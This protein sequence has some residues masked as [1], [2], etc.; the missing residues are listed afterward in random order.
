MLL[1]AGF[2]CFDDPLL[3]ASSVKILHVLNPSQSQT[4]FQFSESV[5]SIHQL[6][7]ETLSEAFLRHSLTPSFQTACFSERMPN[8]YISVMSRLG[9]II[10][11]S[12]LDQRRVS[13][14]R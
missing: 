9:N 3:F 8:T 1:I 2:F 7:N 14:S 10:I 11:G 6:V 5:R 12:L 4:V 13:Q